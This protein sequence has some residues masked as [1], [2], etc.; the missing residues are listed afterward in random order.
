[1]PN[2]YH[3]IV[4]TPRANLVQGLGWLQVTYTVRFNRKHQRSGHLFQGRYSAQV[5]ESDEY[6]QELIR[7]IHTNP[8]RPHNR[9]KEI[10][11]ERKKELDDYQWSSHRA[12]AGLIEPP[13]WLSLRWM[14]YWGKKP[15]TAHN[16][17]INFI[18]SAFGGRLESPLKHIRGGLVL[19]NDQF[20]DRIKAMISAK[21][22]KEEKRWM[23]EAGMEKIRNLINQLLER[24]TD[25]RIKMWIRVR[26]GGER[27]TDVGESMGYRDGSGVLQA[28]KRLEKASQRDNELFMKLTSLRNQVNLSSVKS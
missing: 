8:V 16:N 7:Y 15:I 10:A 22:G 20:M 13:E 9:N 2:H 1:M 25:H 18:D 23:A 6:A 4:E 19:G 12:Y 26:L 21:R 17:Y 24:E 27:L 14:E 11:G 5:V 28:I 3:L